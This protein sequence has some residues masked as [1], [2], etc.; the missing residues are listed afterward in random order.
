M[1]AIHMPSTPQNRQSCLNGAK[2]ITWCCKGSQ[3][4]LTLVKDEL[5]SL[6]TTTIAQ[7]LFTKAPKPSQ[8]ASRDK[9]NHP[10]ILIADPSET[11]REVG[12]AAARET[13]EPT[14]LAYHY[15]K[16]LPRTLAINNSFR[17]SASLLSI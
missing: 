1:D 11:W 7:P 3:Q 15:C 9:S 14:F 2:I 6:Q 16:P 4:D 12:L 10:T 8:T 13:K 5:I 17:F